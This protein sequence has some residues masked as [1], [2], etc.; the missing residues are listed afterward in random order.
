LLFARLA[1]L[2]AWRGVGEPPVPAVLVGE[3]AEEIG[4]RAFAE[5]ISVLRRHSDP[6]VVIVS[7]TE[8]PGAGRP[9]VTVSRCGQV[10][11]KERPP[12]ERTAPTSV[13]TSSWSSRA[14]NTCV[15]LLASVT[16]RS[17]NGSPPLASV[18]GPIMNSWSIAEERQV[19]PR[20]GRP[21]R[22]KSG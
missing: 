19:Q 6:S 9:A 13:W 21:C 15:A 3:G 20:R 16:G 8:R 5:A 1:V 18:V 10:V 22:A 4:S 17:T 2:G 14:V 12:A 11:L 7:D